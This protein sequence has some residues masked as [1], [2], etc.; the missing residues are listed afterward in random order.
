MALAAGEETTVDLT[1][2]HADI[3][4]GYDAWSIDNYATFACR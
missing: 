3:D 4:N 2:L 1:L